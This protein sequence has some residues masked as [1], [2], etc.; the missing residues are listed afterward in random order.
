MS[1]QRILRF[2]TFV[3]LLAMAMPAAA[4]IGS[5]GISGTVK[6]SSGAVLPGVTVEVANHALIEGSRTTVTDSAGQ[7]RV[8]DLR[9]GEYTV[10]F[11]LTG[12]KTVKREGIT[13][14]AA[15]VATVNADLSVGSLEE[16]ITVTGESPL[17]DVRSTASGAVMN[18]EKLDAIPTGKD[19][20]A[21]GQIIPGVTTAT[22]DVGGTQVEDG[23]P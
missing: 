18:R 9:P 12:F 20:F 11:T 13:L 22:P 1:F 10:T 14:P 16:A 5:S 4:Q 7:Y 6:D 21:V 19:P 3:A 8:T 23:H 17:V 15:F 2:L